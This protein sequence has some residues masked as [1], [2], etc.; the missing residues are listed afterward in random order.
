MLN[1]SDVMRMTPTVLAAES[2]PM[3]NIVGGKL[4]VLEHIE[5][6]R[7]HNRASLHTGFQ[8]IFVDILKAMV[9]SLG[10]MLSP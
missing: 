8:I 3:E 4:L 5:T 2:T 7:K 1:S 10:N 9:S 6:S